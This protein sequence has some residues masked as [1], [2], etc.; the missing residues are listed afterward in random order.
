MSE[1]TNMA[2]YRNMTRNILRVYRAAEAHHVEAGLTWY[3][4]AFTECEKR[5][6]RHDWPVINVVCAFATLSPRITYRQNL[7]LL[8]ALVVGQHKPVGCLSRSWLAASRALGSA[9]PLGTF[10]KEALKT[11]NFARAILGDRNAVVVDVWSARAAGVGESMVRSTRGYHAVA[12]A[13][14]R[15]ARRVNISARDLQAITWCHARGA[16]A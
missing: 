12:E 15:G 11:G 9:D 2:E 14:R 5:A 3:D 8:D 4:M 7:E 10:S 1:P 6:W 13:Y 16:A